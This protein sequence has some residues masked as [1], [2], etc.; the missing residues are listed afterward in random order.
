M[1]LELWERVCFVLSVLFLS[2][3]CGKIII[4][5]DK[6]LIIFRATLKIV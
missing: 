5:N 6:K 4:I 1:D 2:E 3:K